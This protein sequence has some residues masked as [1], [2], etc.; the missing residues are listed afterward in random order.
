MDYQTYT[1]EDFILDQKFRQW[2]LNPD[3]ESNAFWEAWL[4]QH[5]EKA[6]VIEDARELLLEISS[7]THILYDKEEDEMW[8]G[9]S[10]QISEEED[11]I[12]PGQPVISLY[13]PSEH[14]T[15]QLVKKVYWSH[16]RIGKIA[17]SVSIFLSL[18]MAYFFSTF[19]TSTPVTLRQAEII[20][21]ENPWGQRATL[22]LSDG[23]EV[24]LNAGSSIDYD[25][26]FGQHERVIQLEGE[27][28]FQVAEDAH[29]PFKVKTGDL[30]TQALGTSFNVK[31]YTQS[32]VE[33]ALVTGKVSVQR[34][35]TQT[36]TDTLLLVPGE[37]ALYDEQA[38]FTKSHFDAKKVLSWKDGIIY[39]DYAD[40]ETVLHALEKWYGVE[41]TVVNATKKEWNYAASFD[42]RSLEHVLMSISFAMD[43][44]YTIDGK[45]ITLQYN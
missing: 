22:L 43:F 31:A 27:A 28:F 39:F 6:G 23:T 16:T 45:S 26:V 24:T 44:Q 8:K 37:S 21:K 30:I 10:K 20:H 12:N 35:P 18:G 5:P 7:H 4:V 25:K 38:G 42:N 2:I 17:A 41:I 40:E 9:I 1:A 36:S 32:T 29:R 33:I 15:Q 14:D 11:A 3:Q 34:Q 13:I 19:S